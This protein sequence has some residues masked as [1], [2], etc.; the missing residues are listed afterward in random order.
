MCS[1]VQDHLD[2]A[3]QLR[4]ESS[5]AQAAA[6]AETQAAAQELHEAG[7]PVRDIG[8]LFGVSFQRA[9]QLMEKPR[10]TMTPPRKKSSRYLHRDI[11]IV[12]PVPRRVQGSSD[13]GDVHFE[14]TTVDGIVGIQRRDNAIG[15]PVGRY[16]SEHPYMAHPSTG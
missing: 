10:A 3:R 4:Q 14:L 11:R 1:S 9:H 12:I 8:R 7:L 2:Q 5:Q 16:R 15:G 6:T 13:I